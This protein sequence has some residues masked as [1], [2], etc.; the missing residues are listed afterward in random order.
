M[1][2]AFS[3][4]M[5][6]SVLGD[7]LAWLGLLWVGLLCLLICACGNLRGPYPHLDKISGKRCGVQ[8][9]T[10][11][12]LCEPCG[13]PGHSRKVV[14]GTGAPL[15]SQGSVKTGDLCGG[16]AHTVSSG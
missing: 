7:L 14:L 1:S 16:G 15:L 9:L 6:K 13:R 5:G 11:A 8:G 3:S 2:K 10:E 12:G 4:D